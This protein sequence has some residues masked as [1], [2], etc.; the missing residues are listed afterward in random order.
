MS[1]KFWDTWPKYASIR[2]KISTE[3]IL[4]NSLTDF[5]MVVNATVRNWYNQ[6]VFGEEAWYTFASYEDFFE[7]HMGMSVEAFDTCILPLPEK[8]ATIKELKE[9][10]LWMPRK[11]QENNFVL[12]DIKTVRKFIEGGAVTPGSLYGI[13]SEMEFD[14]EPR[15]EVKNF[16][17]F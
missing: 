4:L 13:I 3:I 14:H 9:K 17:T 11:F 7:K 10:A 15:F 2:D 16:D 8:N 5:R 6:G 12:K 1:N